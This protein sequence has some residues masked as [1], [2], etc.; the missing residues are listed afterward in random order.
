MKIQI[1][2]KDLAGL[3]GRVAKAAAVS[4]TIPVLKGL[5]LEAKGGQLLAKATNMGVSIKDTTSEIQLNEEGRVLVNAK[6]FENFVKQ[7][8]DSVISLEVE[9]EE[10]VLHVK[11]GR[12]KAKVPLITGEYPDFPVCGTLVATYATEEL[13]KAVALTL[14]SIAKGHFREVFNGILLDIQNDKT[15]LVGSDTHRL[16][17]CEIGIGGSSP[18]QLIVPLAGIGEILRIDAEEIS[19]YTSDNAIMYRAGEL[20]II[21]PLIAGQYPDYTKVIP[22]NF[23]CEV[24]VPSKGLR[25]ALQRLNT[26]P[27]EG[28]NNIP[29]VKVQ[30]NGGVILST[31]GDSG[32]INEILEAEKTGE[33]TALAFNRDYFLEAVKVITTEEMTISFSGA[34]SPA[35]LAG[36][37]ISQVTLVPL[38]INS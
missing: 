14:P 15:V 9:E 32:E 34:L 19:I 36:D 31:T 21:T 35:K 2:K 24:K 11:Y 16:A 3:V 5:Y 22:Q 6:Y 38:R 29:I 18:Q 4:D 23:V 20:D 8:P 12:N 28:K 33:D 27:V 17:S 13:K 1:E 30:I 37:S 25:Q 10:N 7:L 26:L